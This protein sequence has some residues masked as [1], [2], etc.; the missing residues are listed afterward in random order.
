MWEIFG[1]L[2]TVV[3]AVPVVRDAFGAPGRHA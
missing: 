1:Y 3:G 2:D